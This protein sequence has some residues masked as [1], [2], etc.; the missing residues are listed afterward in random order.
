MA[1]TTQSQQFKITEA[2][3]TADRIGGFNANF[4]DVRTS[5]AELNIFESLDKPY[6]TGTVVILDDKALFDKINFQGTE[7]FEVE[8]SSVE[9]DLDMIMES[10]VCTCLH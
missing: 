9:N 7:R 3:I 6:L 2:A 10:L 4:F 1:K 5:I 8:M